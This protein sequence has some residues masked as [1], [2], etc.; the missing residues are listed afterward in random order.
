MKEVLSELPLATGSVSSAAWVRGSEC[1]A[2]GQ[3]FGND[4]V[5]DS[6]CSFLS[7]TH[8]Q[9]LSFASLIAAAR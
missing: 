6:R 8:E 2:L 9:G 3:H 5:T 7:H 4:T 1:S